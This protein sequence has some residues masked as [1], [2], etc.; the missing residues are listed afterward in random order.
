M[1]YKVQWDSGEV[2]D[3]QDVEDSETEDLDAAKYKA[4]QLQLEG[5][6]FGVTYIVRNT[7]SNDVEYVPRNEGGGR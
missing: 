6:N 4:D 7:E 5:T 3:W 1:A 2:D